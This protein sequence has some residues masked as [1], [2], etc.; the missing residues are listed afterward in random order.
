MLIGDDQYL[1]RVPT[2][3]PT[4][5]QVPRTPALPL[6]D[7]TCDLAVGP[8]SVGLLTRARL[9]IGAIGN[10]PQKR[11]T[12]KIGLVSQWLPITSTSFPLIGCS[13]SR[14]PAPGGRWGAVGQ[15]FN[16]RGQT[17]RPRKI[18]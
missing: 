4:V 6:T 16:L 2:K 1:L 8:T 10:N 7:L 9:V 5:L 15:G 3:V 17:P 12:F 14:A 18:I 13:G 11:P